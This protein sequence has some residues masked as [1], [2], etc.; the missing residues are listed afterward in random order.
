MAERKQEMVS[1]FQYWD[2]LDEILDHVQEGVYITD[3]EA[4]TVYINHTYELISGLLKTEM[5]GKNMKDLV[6]N[7][8]ISASGTLMVLESGESI[9]I[10]QSFRTGKRAIITSA[11]VYDDP[12]ERTHIIMIVTSVREITE[13][14]SVRKELKKLEQQNRLYASELARLHN[15]MSENVEIVAVDDSSV[16]T[17]HLAQRVS[18]VDNPVFI[19]GEAGVGKEKMARFIHNYSSRSEFLFMRINFSVIPKND[20]IKYLFGYED[21][22]KGEYHMGILESADGGTVYLDEFAEMP[23][24]VRGRF[25]SLLRDGTCVLGDG[26][27]HKLNIRI[28]A[29]SKYSFEELQRLKLIENDLLEYF[30]LFP[31]H[32]PPLRERRDD[33]IP[34][35]EYFLKQ[36]QRKTGE[37]KYFTR[38]CYEKLL[39]Y[40]WP[41]NV[42]EVHNL[43][44]RAVIVSTGEAVTPED[45]MLDA[46]NENELVRTE[47][48]VSVQ[49]V[50]DDGVD[51][52]L[53][54]AKLESCYM[55][56]AFAK[57]QNIRVAA[58]KLGMDSSTFVRKR[59]RY[60]KMGL[61][62]R[63]RKK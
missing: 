31:L 37:K 14:Y 39:G 54:L 42:R 27:L 12:V 15:E 11:P 40:E 10:E 48:Y 47:D 63:E 13:L 1:N 52:K 36:Y 59:Q 20:P 43:V 9:T 35:L 2:Y 16:K 6:E 46:G 21:P 17:V 30:S 58:S 22:E 34:L 50:M 44:Q 45:I 57:Y 60:E 4:N 61:M 26:M 5:L 23:Q 38:T 29:G 51:L 32:I 3:S 62:D 19:S 7:G 53:E 49:P 55:S 56:Q 41:G 28:I 25:L 8:A 33:I 24:V 18:L